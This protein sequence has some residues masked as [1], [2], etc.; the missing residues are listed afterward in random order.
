MK[1]EI[2]FAFDKLGKALDK[3]KTGARDAKE[4]L[5]QDGVIKRFEFTFELAWK[6][7]KIA[8]EN[9]G[10]LANSPKMIM[11]EA[12]RLGWIKDEQICLNML[13]DCNRTSHIYNESIAQEI[14]DRIKNE[15]VAKIEEILAI[16]KTFI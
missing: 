12:F 9:H 2:E 11:Q 13:E 7:V 14:L 8:L 16:R 6:A 5:E 15:Y 10:V 3:L 1:K 4:E